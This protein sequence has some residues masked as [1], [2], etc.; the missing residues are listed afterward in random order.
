VDALA[1]AI[2][3]FE[4]AAHR[5]EPRALR[6]RAAMFDRPRFAQRIR[7]WV[8]GRWAAAAARPAC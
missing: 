8:D 6:A 3:T 2:T 5:F 7:E 1:G 4:A